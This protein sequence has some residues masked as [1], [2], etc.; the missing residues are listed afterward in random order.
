[1]QCIIYLNVCDVGFEK[2]SDGP[3]VSEIIRNYLKNV[4]ARP[5]HYL[6]TD[7]KIRI[8]VFIINRMMGK[9]MTFGAN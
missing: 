9:G 3:E 8:R 1:M 7:V 6:S 5:P 2:W 4:C